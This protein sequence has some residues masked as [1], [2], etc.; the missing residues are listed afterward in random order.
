MKLIA[1]EIWWA[2]TERKCQS[3][4]GRE[5]CST[6]FQDLRRPETGNQEDPSILA[7]LPFTELRVSDDPRD[8]PCEEGRCFPR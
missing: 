2:G 6:N 4:Q 1:E 8:G 7:P 3:R 5:D